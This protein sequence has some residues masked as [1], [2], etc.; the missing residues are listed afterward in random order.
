MATFPSL[1]LARPSRRH[2]LGYI[3]LAPAVLLVALIILYPLIISVDL[4]FQQVKL[5]RL[6]A[7]R[8]PFTLANY[9]RLFTSPDF[10]MTCWVTLKLVVVVSSACLALGLG[11]ALLVNNHFKGRNLARLAVALPWAIPEVIATVIFAWIFDSSFGLMN[12][13]FVTLGLSNTMINWFSDTTAA[14]WVVA[15]TMIWKGYPF[16]SIMTLAGL[17]SIPSDFYSAAKVDGANVFQR[18]RYITIP[19]LMPVLGVTIILVVLWV[20]RDFSIIKVLTDGGP[21][22]S[23]QTLSIMTYNEAFGFFN[24]GYASAVGVVTLIICVVASIAMLGRET[25]SMY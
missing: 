20:F 15:I 7:A 10:W 2:W 22:K 16:V 21:L 8:K 3:L 14:F 24:F 6:D 17:Q 4:S 18:F 19:S 13:L 9:E 1:D 11:T 25:K 23:T 5:V 12:W